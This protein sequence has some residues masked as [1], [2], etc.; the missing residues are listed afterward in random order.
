MQHWTKGSGLAAL[1][2]VAAASAVAAQDAAPAVT[3]VGP[4]LP[5]DSMELGAKYM[6][7][8]LNYESEDLYEALTANMQENLGS[9]ADIFDQMGMLFEQ[10]GSQER[11]ISQRFW[12]RNGKPQ[13]WHTA[14]FTNLAEPMV[15]RFVIEPDGKIS[16]I[17][18]NAES[19]NPPVDDPDQHGDAE[20]ETGD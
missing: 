4:H 6:D 10:I 20:S 11:V 18:V 19:Q 15:F 17:G 16:G 14:E 13:Y 7:Y 3:P 8:V 5:A 1:L 9:P 2:I 12:M